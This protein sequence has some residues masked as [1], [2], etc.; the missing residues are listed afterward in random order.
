MPE[1][2]LQPEVQL[3]VMGVSGVGKTTVAR[4]VATALGWEFTEGD[5]LHSDANRATLASGRPLTDEDRG[6][7]LRSIADHLAAQVAAGRPGVTTCS[8]LRRAYRDLLRE[9]CP[10]VVFCHLSADPELVA[11][12][13]RRRTDH[14]MPASQL[15]DQLATLEPL[16][17]D[18]PG[19]VVPADVDPATT[20]T[21]ALAALG[22][23][24]RGS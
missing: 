23:S 16:E 22:L 15:A 18:E 3:V 8:A 5:D 14:F 9:G 24:G 13:M 7:W 17:P 2:Q 10:E 12:R 11:E 21:R 1:V 6:P 19:V 4:G 20:V